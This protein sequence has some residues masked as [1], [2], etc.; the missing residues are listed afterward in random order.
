ME[1]GEAFEGLTEY[2]K[3]QIKAIRAWKNEKPGVVGHAFGFVTAPVARLMQGVVPQFAVRKMLDAA[4]WA[5]YG[6]A[7][8]SDILRDGEVEKISD[9]RQRDLP[10]CDKLADSV[11]D[12]SIGMAVAEGSVTGAVGLAGFAVDIPTLLTFALRTAHKVGL[13]YGYEATD[14][15]D[16][17]FAFGILS[18]AGA[19]SV[20][21]KIGALT[22]L[23]SIETILRR[24][25][26]NAIVE[27]AAGRQF[28]EEG[29]II[30]VRDLA[31]R[32]GVNLTKRKLLQIVPFLG[33][34]IGAS[35]NGLYM[36]D[37]GWAARRAFQERWLI[38]NKKIDA[39]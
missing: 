32:I 34:G 10:L 39:I 18:A 23:H 27:R 37:V 3:E 19:N 1:N 12:W 14:G 7:D 31:K 6:L 5:A 36:K 33:A 28:S 25:T 20:A 35:A 30:A 16:N 38:D 4:N 13:C 17:H 8:V 2:E 26:W 11:H 9:L 29:V 24:R 22:T 15:L 21:E